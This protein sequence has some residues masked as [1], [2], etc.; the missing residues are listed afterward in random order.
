M[1][2]YTND[3]GHMTNMAVMSI[4]GNNLKILL[5]RLMTLKLGM[6]HCLCNYYYDCSKYDPGWT[7]TYF[8]PR[9]TWS[10]R[11]CMVKRENCYFL[12]LLQP[13]VSKLL[14]TFN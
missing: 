5:F 7:L 9:S 6:L 12:E 13:W 8:M 3:L 10:D 1:K 2:I 4:Y 11:L 14:E